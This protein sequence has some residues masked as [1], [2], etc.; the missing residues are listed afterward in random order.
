MTPGALFDL[1]CSDDT[2]PGTQIVGPGNTEA[3]FEPIPIVR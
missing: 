1:S 2:P 3:Q